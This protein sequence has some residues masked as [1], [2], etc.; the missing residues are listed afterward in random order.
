MTV[1]FL[2]DPKSK[3]KKLLLRVLDMIVPQDKIT[4]VEDI[5]ALESQ[6]RRQLYGDLMVLLLPADENELSSIIGL[7]E[8]FGD[9]PIILILPDRGKETTAL[10]YKLRPRFITY[11][12]SNFLDV[13]T[14]LIK[15]KNKMETR[16][17]FI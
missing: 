1:F 15:M 10:G 6:L 7:K 4:L 8:L 9:M 2:A 5:T 17:D 16:K 12:D 13:A 11:S 3:A 14:V